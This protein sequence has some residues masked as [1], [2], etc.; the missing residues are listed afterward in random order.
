M[1]HFIF[2][3]YVEYSNNVLYRNQFMMNMAASLPYQESSGRDYIMDLW[4]PETKYIENDNITYSEDEY[5]Q[6]L[7]EFE[8]IKFERV[9]AKVDTSL[10]EP[11]SP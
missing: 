7:S 6:N 5:F 3:Q 8:S 10:W 4:K 1:P 9:A 11:R 2:D